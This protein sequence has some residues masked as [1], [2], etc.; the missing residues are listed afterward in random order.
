MNSNVASWIDNMI[1]YEWV[2]SWPQLVMRVSTT[3]NTCTGRKHHVED[4]EVVQAESSSNEERVREEDGGQTGQV[5]QEEVRGEAKPYRFGFPYGI[6]LLGAVLPCGIPILL[7]IS[8]LHLLRGAQ[9]NGRLFK[10]H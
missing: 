4:L 8:I 5:G 10:V 7:T 1:K 9:N 6:M 3:Y 2:P